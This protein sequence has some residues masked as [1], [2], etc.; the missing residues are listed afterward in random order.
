MV[1][2]TTLASEEFKADHEHMFALLDRFV[3]HEDSHAIPLV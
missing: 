1:T 3:E 2:Q